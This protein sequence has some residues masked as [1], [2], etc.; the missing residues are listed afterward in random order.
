MSQQEAKRSAIQSAPDLRRICKAFRAGCWEPRRRT[1]PPSTPSRPS[2]YLPFT[3]S[4]RGPEK[5]VFLRRTLGRIDSTCWR[6]NPKLKVTDAPRVLPSRANSRTCVK[7]GSKLGVENAAR[8]AQCAQI[9]QTACGSRAA[10]KSGR[11]VPPSG[12]PRS[13][14]WFEDVFAVQDEI[15]G[16]VAGALNVT[17]LGSSRHRQSEIRKYTPSSCRAVI[18]AIKTARTACGKQSECSQARSK[19][20]PRPP[21]FWRLSQCT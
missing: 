15:A 18:C 7:S 21:R 14:G 16:A 2:P 17:L 19:S 3:N 12:S 11:R 1:A 4:E 13:T 20:T 8:S 10:G 5:R 6:G 9:G